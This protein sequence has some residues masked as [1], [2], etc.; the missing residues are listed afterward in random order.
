VSPCS[1]LTQSEAA[2]ITGDANIAQVSGNG[3]AASNQCLYLDTSSTTIN[4]AEITVLQAQPSVSSQVL[5][6]D[7]SDAAK[8]SSGTFQPV[9]GIGDSAF[10]ETGTTEAGL[11]FAR[12]STVVAIVASSGRSTADM[13]TSI[14][15]AATALASSL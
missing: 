15:Q 2:A 9:S 6:Q 10:S 1:A 14:E 5:Q 12:G 13:L 7:L 4:S 11:V 3:G 8:G